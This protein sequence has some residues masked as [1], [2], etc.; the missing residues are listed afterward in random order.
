VGVFSTP[1]YTSS[2]IEGYGRL[3]MNIVGIKKV[4]FIRSLSEV[5]RGQK[6]GVSAYGWS[7]MR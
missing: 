3:P 2:S 1:I 7:A 4:V 5:L 6:N